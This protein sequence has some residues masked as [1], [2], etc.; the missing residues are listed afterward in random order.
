MTGLSDAFVL[1]TSSAPFSLFRS[2]FLPPLVS[3][4]STASCLSLIVESMWG[5]YTHRVRKWPDFSLQKV[6]F[7]GLTG[8]F[9]G[10]MFRNLSLWSQYCDLSHLCWRASSW[11]VWDVAEDTWD[12]AKDLLMF[13]G[14]TDV[15]YQTLIDHSSDSS[16]E[17]KLS[18]L[19]RNYF[20]G[21]LQWTKR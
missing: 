19:Y 3:L 1:S 12:V 8:F 14:T 6:V 16:P 7:R 4:P 5:K 21:S 11:D 17:Q 20:H 2:F 9:C 13:L 15:S 18:S 10:L